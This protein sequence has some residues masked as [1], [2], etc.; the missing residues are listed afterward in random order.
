MTDEYLKAHN[1]QLTELKRLGWKSKGLTEL[2]D[3]SHTAKA[4]HA[5]GRVM[6]GKGQEEEDALN[7]RQ[8]KIGGTIQIPK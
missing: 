3:G 6:V 5:D 4:V 1:A 8:P 7:D 2:D